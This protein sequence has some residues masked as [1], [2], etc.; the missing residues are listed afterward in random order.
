MSYTAL[1]LMREKNTHDF[2]RELGPFVPELPEAYKTGMDLK[3][4][5]LRFLHERCE[6]LRFDAD[7]TQKE[8]SGNYQ[9]TSTQAFQIP[10]NMQMDID[11]LCLARELETFIDSGVAEDAY[12]VYYSFLEM[13]TGTYGS[14]QKMVELLSEFEMNAS[15]LLMKHRDHY[16]HSVYVFTLGLAIYEAN[17]T[18]RDAFNKFYGLAEKDEHTAAAFFLEYW[19]MTALFHDIGYPFEIPFEQVLAYFEVDKHQRGENCPYIA[20]RNLAPLEQ[21]GEPMQMQLEKLFGRKF[22]NVPEL[23]AYDT[24]RLL[25][26]AYGF[27]EGYL[28]RVISDKPLNPEHFG[29]F[30]DHACFSAARLLQEMKGP[31]GAAGLTVAHV[32]AL[33]AIVL[34]NSLF[35]FSVAYYKDPQK[36]KP[37]LRMEQHP[38][39]FLLM[40][41]DELQC[42]DRTA[43]GRNSRTELHPMAASFN[44]SNGKIDATYIYDIGEKEKINAYETAAKNWKPEDGKP[45]R[46]KAYSDMAEK[47]QRFLTDIEHIVDLKDLP[48]T[49]NTDL[50]KPDRKSKHTYLSMSSFLHI[51]DFAV[52]LNGRYRYQGQEDSVTTEELEHD[53]EELSLEYKLSNI[54]QVKAFSKYLNAIDCFY[55]DRPVDFDEVRGFTPEQIDIFAPMEHA[56]WVREHHALGWRCDDVYEELGAKGGNQDIKALRERLR[57]HKLC[58][59]SWNS[60]QD[61]IEHYHKLPPEEQD[62]DWKPFY[63]MLRLIRKYDGLRIYRLESEPAVSEAQD[64]TSAS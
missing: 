45:P 22:N 61:I 33:S 4:A 49:V 54:N 21:L 7:K 13:F 28:Q 50:L 35:K 40:L 25:G 1:D 17:K 34:H 42:W 39:A 48:L 32:D 55:T 58:M 30:M 46:L 62:K 64:S 37:P 41:C 20:Y 51:Y 59:N 38:L 5:A 19:G 47:G 31:M 43:Y 36:R 14:A 9:G 8:S 63:T 15:S 26:E 12:T 53:F 2:G 24:A 16:S 29:Y 60:E 52:A 11:R 18:F 44:L 27:C 3:S 10:Y 23:L 57:C 56:R 6:G